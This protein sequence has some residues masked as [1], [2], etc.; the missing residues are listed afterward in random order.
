[1]YQRMNEELARQRQAD[2]RRLA[3]GRRT[4]LAAKRRAGS[5]RVSASTRHVRDANRSLRA[6]AGWW[7][8]GLGLKLAVG[9]H[10]RAAGSPRP[11]GSRC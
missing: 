5:T 6:R 1:M 2:M 11:A 8:I 7:L 10:S 3:A 4:E 9:P